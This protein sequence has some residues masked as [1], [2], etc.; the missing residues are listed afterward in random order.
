[1]PAARARTGM[2]RGGNG[3]EIKPASPLTINQIASSKVPTLRVTVTA[4]MTSGGDARV[5]CVAKT[6]PNV[7]HA[8]AEREA[9]WHRRCS[10]VTD[11]ATL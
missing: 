11:A 4:I 5:E 1:M 7:H 10:S 3:S 8:R 2:T 6:T 9:Y